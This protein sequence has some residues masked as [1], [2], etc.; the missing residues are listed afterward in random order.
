MFAAGFH[1]GSGNDP[2]LGVDVDHVAPKTS[3]DLPAVRTRN[4]RARAWL[5]SVSRSFAM[6]GRVMPEG[7][8][9][10]LR[11]DQ[12]QMTAPC[13]RILP[14]P[15]TVGFPVIKHRLDPAA[16]AR[17]SFWNPAPNRLQ[18]AKHGL[19]VDCVDRLIENRLAIIVD[20]CAP[21]ARVNIGA[22]F[23]PLRFYEF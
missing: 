9:L 23:A 7:K 21:L 1:A 6:H 13:S 2:D 19:R 5:D 16:E 10:P 20:R 18:D 4:S 3:P 12:R 17:S 15:K 11:Q 8:L 22:P 14:R